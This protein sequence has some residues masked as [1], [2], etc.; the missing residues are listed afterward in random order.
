[1][2][3]H[4]SGKL[5]VQALVLIY[6]AAIVPSQLSFWLTSNMCHPNPIIYSDAV[7][8][9]LFLVRLDDSIS[10]FSA[11][12]VKFILQTDLALNFFIGVYIDAVYCED[13]RKVNSQDST[14]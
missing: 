3:P 12:Y 8:D 10:G 14:V 9:S 6:S 2:D 4:S 13:L 1:M 7:V 5:L 11:L